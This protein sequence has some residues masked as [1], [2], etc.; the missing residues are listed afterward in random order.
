[1]MIIRSTTGV[2]MRARWF[3]SAFLLF[4]APAFAGQ[5]QWQSPEE[6]LLN[7]NGITTPRP[8][9]DRYAIGDIGHCDFFAKRGQ[10]WQATFADGGSLEVRCE[11]DKSGF[12]PGFHVWYRAASGKRTEVAHCIFDDGL[13]RGWYFSSR[14]NLTRLVWQ[15]VDG[16]KSDGGS[17]RI[18]KTHSTGPGRGY[19][20]VL[21]W[22]FDSSNKTLTWINDKYRY[23]NQRPGVAPRLPTRGNTSL[24]AYVGPRLNELSQS[25]V[26]TLE[27]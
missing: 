12:L 16:G 8:G 15:N 24:E 7:D 10:R 1:M 18:D 6:E 23:A 17:R 13:N 14:G 26:K 2:P 25:L 5:Q 27:Y 9:E 3:G 19:I 4:L 20:D 11:P 22:V 21:V